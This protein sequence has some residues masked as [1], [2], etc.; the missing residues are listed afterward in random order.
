MEK[1]GKNKFYI[2]QSVEK[3]VRMKIINICFN[4]CFAKLFDQNKYLPVSHGIS[5]NLLQGTWILSRFFFH[6]NINTEESKTFCLFFLS[7]C[8]DFNK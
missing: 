6:R 1:S 4:S 5:F 7:F 2:A 8:F 3:I